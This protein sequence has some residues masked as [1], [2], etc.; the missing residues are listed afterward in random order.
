M[1]TATSTAPGGTMMSWQ[2]IFKEK[3][4][5]M[6]V[7]EQW[8]LQE[9]D[10]LRVKA[11]SPHWKEFV[12]RCALGRFQCSQC[13][14]KWTSAKVLILFHMRQCPGWGII[15]MRVFRQE[16]RRCPNP[17][18]EYP[19]FSLETVERI[20]HNLMDVVGPGDCKEELR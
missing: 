4:A 11:L 1:V 2:D 12:Q 10:T 5:E 18:L 15:R 20:L 17:Q 13:C 3:L 9:D 16:C 14:H 19:E 6:H 8:T 7:T